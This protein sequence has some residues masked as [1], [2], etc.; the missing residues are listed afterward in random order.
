MGPKIS[1]IMAVNRYDKYLPPAIDS[2]LQ[3]T[4]T[5][6]EFIIVANACTDEL[7]S[8][9][10][11]VTDARV[12]IFRTSIPQLPFNLNYGVDQSLAPYI[13]RMDADDIA[14][15]ERLQCQYDHMEQHPEVS[16]LGSNVELINTRD[17]VIGV[18]QLPLTDK[19]IRSK[20]STSN[21]LVHPA[22]M[23]RKTFIYAAKGYLG[24]FKSED[25]DLWIRALHLPGVQFANIGRVLLKYRMHPASTQG[26]R[27]AYSE[28]PGYF[29]REFLFTG[30]IKFL[31]AF[32]IGIFKYIIKARKKNNS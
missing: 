20:I 31:S 10:Q 6:F 7:W 25:Y 16:V 19:E 3:Q 27:L 4:F 14:V 17:E 30:R 8:Y 12:R 28:I 32:L 21:V 15:P 29:L 11:S 1:V 9:L 26:S 22:V 24:G 2:I 5:A 23:Y 13:A 18:R